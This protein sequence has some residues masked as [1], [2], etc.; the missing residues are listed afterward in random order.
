[1]F[2]NENCVSD[3]NA[4]TINKHATDPEANV[5]AVRL[6]RAFLRQYPEGA[7]ENKGCMCQGIS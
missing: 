2:E 3:K 6:M 7:V 1:V 4:N 5:F